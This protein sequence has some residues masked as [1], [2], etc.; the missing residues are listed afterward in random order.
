VRAFSDNM[1]LSSALAKIPIYVILKEDAPVIGAAHEALAI[2][3]KLGGF[4]CVFT[5]DLAKSR[6]FEPGH[7]NGRSA[8]VEVCPALPGPGKTYRLA[9]R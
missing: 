6:R 5:S 9:H 8:A 7:A 1:K 3:S 2:S 4:T